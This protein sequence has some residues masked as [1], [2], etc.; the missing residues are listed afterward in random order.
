MLKTSIFCRNADPLS[1]GEKI[2]HVHVVLTARGF[3]H[4]P[5]SEFKKSIERH[6]LKEEWPAG[7][8]SPLFRQSVLGKNLNSQQLISDYLARHRRQSSCSQRD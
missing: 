7:A 2:A 1:Q 6:L 5:I 8:N 4:F 3:L